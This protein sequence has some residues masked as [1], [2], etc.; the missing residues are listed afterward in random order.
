VEVLGLDKDRA[1]Y[2]EGWGRHLS[3]V[4]GGLIMELHMV[5]LLMEERVEGVEIYGVFLCM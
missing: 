5:H 4:Y 3:G 1:S 2:L